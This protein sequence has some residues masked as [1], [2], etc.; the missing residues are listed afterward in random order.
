MENMTTEKNDNIIIT[1]YK[2]F[3][4]IRVLKVSSRTLRLI[5]IVNSIFIIFGIIF[6]LS[7][8]YQWAR[9]DQQK[10][11]IQIIRKENLIIK[12][13]VE[14]KA[15]CMP[16]TAI[17]L[18]QPSEPQH[19]EDGKTAEESSSP[20]KI[21]EIKLSVDN[22]S[23][24]LILTY[25]IQNVNQGGDLIS[26]YLVTLATS[27]NFIT[28]YPEAINL[29]DTKNFISFEKGEKFSVRVYRKSIAKLPLPQNN[30]LYDKISILVYSLNGE[31]LESR[32][33]NVNE[34][35]KY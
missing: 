30:K 12:K 13:E 2:N 24:E 27:N 32:D 10:R 3:S 14:S 9:N 26:G 34:Y 33:Y 21:D 4:R 31:L 20:I 22:T 16:Q 29:K 1:F 35:V 23:N 15:A 28:A 19:E 17:N 8:L 5:I 6:S 7:F 11:T 18:P 25:T